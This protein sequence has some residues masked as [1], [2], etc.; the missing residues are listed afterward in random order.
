MAQPAEKFLNPLLATAESEETVSTLLGHMLDGPPVETC[1]IN[2]VEVLQALLE[3]RRPQPQGG[4]FYAYSS[5]QDTANC[6]S[7]IER[8]EAAIST[9]FLSGIKPLLESGKVSISDL[10]CNL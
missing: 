2:G 9:A 10:H 5:E 6:Q 8:Q 3:V 1:L 4:G 7:D